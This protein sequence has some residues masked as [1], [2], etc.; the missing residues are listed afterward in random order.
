MGLIYSVFTSAQKFRSTLLA[1]VRLAF[2]IHI[3]VIICTSC[4][5]CKIAPETSSLMFLVLQE[6]KLWKISFAFCLLQE[7][8][9]RCSALNLVD[10][11]DSPWGRLHGHI[12]TICTFDSS[13]SRA[14]IKWQLSVSYVTLSCLQNVKGLSLN[15]KLHQIALVPQK[16]HGQ[17]VNFI[18]WVIHWLI[19]SYRKLRLYA[20]L[21]LRFLS[22]SHVEIE[23]KWK[24]RAYFLSFSIF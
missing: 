4:Q 9:M 16:A 15:P 2:C 20:D 12:Q 18:Y 22:S 23:W 7:L 10:S 11:G 19:W 5:L 24:V 21:C 6:H 17:A 1:S 13:Y 14:D 3:S 8:L